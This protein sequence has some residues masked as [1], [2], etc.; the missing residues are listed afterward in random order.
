VEALQR[1]VNVLRARLRERERLQREATQQ[2][3]V[4]PPW[5]SRTA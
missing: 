5:T 1:E 3:N 2:T 4:R